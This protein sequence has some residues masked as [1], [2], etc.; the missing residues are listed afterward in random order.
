MLLGVVRIPMCTRP[1]LTL[2]LQGGLSCVR[3]L[4]QL[5]LKFQGELLCRH[6]SKYTVLH[7]ELEVRNFFTGLHF[8][9]KAAF[10]GE[11]QNIPPGE[12]EKFAIFS[13]DYISATRLHFGQA[14]HIP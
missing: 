1:K 3:M 13:M 14:Q 4:P 12:L 5:S 7:G 2:I 9:Y 6:T 10:G 11:I 8:G